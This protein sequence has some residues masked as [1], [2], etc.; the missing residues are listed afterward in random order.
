M[1]WSNPP[2]LI[3]MIEV[4]PGEKTN[5]AMVDAAASW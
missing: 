4:I 3:P 2:H 5:Q 1:H